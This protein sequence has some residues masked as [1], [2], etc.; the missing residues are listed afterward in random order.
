MISEALPATDR[1]GAI[2]Q[3]R[4]LI[5]GGSDTDQSLIPQLL[6]AV[7]LAAVAVLVPGEATRVLEIPRLAWSD[8]F[9]AVHRRALPGQAGCTIR[10]EP[11]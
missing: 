10:P 6:L 1:I 9:S 2:G 3:G 7:F 8:V 11:S 4:T 5:G